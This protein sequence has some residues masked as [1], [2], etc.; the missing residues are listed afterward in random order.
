MN[1][2]PASPPQFILRRLSPADAADYRMARLEGLQNHPEAFG[3]SWEDEAAKPL[4]WFTERLEQNVIFGGWL[5]ASR[6]MGLAGLAIP[7]APKLRHKAVLWGM[8]L[9]PEARRTGLAA[10]LLTRVLAEAATTV[11]EFR[12]TVVQSNTAAVRL[13]TRAGFTPYGLEHRALKIGDQYHDDLLMTRS[14]RAQDN[15][16]GGTAA[17]PSRQHPLRSFSD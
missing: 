16:P 11:E 9:R 17:S 3:A 2:L 12:L 8:Y 7:T 10:A 6:L 15:A 1:A 5:D 14:R 13:Y 4:A